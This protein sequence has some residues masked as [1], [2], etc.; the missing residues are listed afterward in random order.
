MK[1]LRLLSAALLLPVYYTALAQ[2]TPPPSSPESEIHLFNLAKENG[3]Y[4]L[5]QG[6]NISNN[7][8]YDN[9]PFFTDD[10]QSILFVSNRDGKQTDVYKY[11][12]KSQKTAQITQ[13]PHN[14]YSPK[15]LNGNTQIS[16]VSEG[17]N[18]YQTVW[19]LNQATGE[20]RWLLN[21]KEPVGYYSA[22]SETGDVLIWSRY[23]RSVQYLNIEKNE[24]RFISGHAIPSSPQQIPNSKRFSFV[25]RQANGEV[26]IKAFDPSNF[27][28]W[29]VAPIEGTNYDYTWAPNGDILR[30]EQNQLYV[31]PTN[32][33]TSKWK[34]AQ[35]LSKHFKGSVSRLAVSADGTKIALVE[36][37]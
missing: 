13:T 1:T 29:P 37:R 11:S 8:G 31:W 10:S 5:K 21:S 15:T 30:V 7:S 27:A 6:Q 36:N 4:V 17:G 12:L 14:E 9:Q 18:P 16:F 26:W 3:N 22:N 19:T 33:K 2:S 35:D 32:N 24:A 20:S 28:I 23:G 25:H 34:R